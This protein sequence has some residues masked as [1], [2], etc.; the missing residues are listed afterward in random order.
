MSAA[1]WILSGAFAVSA[2]AVAAALTGAPA[3]PLVIERVTV[4]EGEGPARPGQTV[5]IEGSRI[6][7]VGGSREVAAPKDARVVDGAGKFLIP[8][9]WDMHVHV[10]F[11]SKKHP[12]GVYLPALVAQ[13][14]TGVRDMGGSPELIAERRKEIAEGRLVGPRIVAAGPWLDGP[15]DNAAFRI[16]VTSAAQ[17]RDAVQSVKKAG[18]EFV[19]V[20]DWLSREAYLAI[21]AEARRQGLPVAGHLPVAVRAQEAAE[22]GQ[23]SIEHLG[24][25]MG[26]LLMAFSSR[27]AE[28]RA[29]YVELKKKGDLA[30]FLHAFDAAT[31]L[32]MLDGYDRAKAASLI[33]DLKQHSVWQC[34]TLV[35]L[36]LNS[37]GYWISS[38]PAQETAGSE[39]AEDKAQLSRLFRQQLAL[40]HAMKEAGLDFLAGTDLLPGM[41]YSVH[42]EMSLLVQTGF[43]PQE[44]L[45]TATLNPARY[46]GLASSLGTVEKGKAADLV[47][48]EANPLAAIH[49]TRKISAVVLGGRLLAKPEL[50]AMAAGA[51]R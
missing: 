1:R 46:L 35:L 38:K 40:V 25:I 19:K 6:A 39:A 50:D 33:A 32:K 51:R 22:A 15:R 42:D 31:N 10:A 14:V 8:G 7:A 13:G 26:G 17:A 34:P 44:A 36:E 21:L 41:N 48:L 4:I 16:I 23:K 18:G 45:K 11:P 49:N 43:T 2:V 28:L 12:Q 27:E 3:P 24:S 29:E 20:H 9:L 30:A 37:K 5:V 47:L